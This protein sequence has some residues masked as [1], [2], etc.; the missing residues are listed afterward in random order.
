MIMQ[1]DLLKQKPFF[2]TEEALA[3][4]RD[5]YNSMSL[6]EK[7]GQLFCPWVATDEKAELQE[8]TDRYHIGGILLRELPAEKSRSVQATLQSLSKIP[9]LSSAN[10]ETGGRG[11][12]Y[13]GTFLG[14]QMAIAATSDAQSAYELGHIGAREAKAVG[15]N[16]AF[17]P[18]VDIDFNDRNPITNVRTYGADPAAVL[19][20]ASAFCCGCMEEGVAPTIKH[21]PGD[22]VDDRDQHLVTSINTLS[23]EDWDETYG[24]IYRSL[25]DQGVLSVM[26]AHIALPAY[27]KRLGGEQHAIVPATCSKV[28]LQS[29]LR[30]QLGFNGLIT[31]DATTMIGFC[32]YLP[33]EQ[34][35]PLCI[36][37][38]CDVLLIC[39]DLE[40]DYRFM[41]E[42]Y[43]KGLLSAERLE[44][45]VLRILATKAA[46]GLHRK[47]IVNA[48][49]MSVIGCE[50]HQRI[51]E[52]IV[53]RA[54]TLVKDTQQL[55]PINA[56]KHRRVL[57]EVMGEG[58]DREAA[59]ETWDQLLTEKG[60]LVT[61]YI[62]EP[63]FE[64][65][66]GNVTSFKQ[67]YDLVLYVVLSDAASNNTTVRLHWHTVWGWGNNTPWF[68]KDVPTLMVSMGNPYHLLD[69][70]MIQ[71]YINTY[72]YS[73]L[74]A[75]RTLEKLLG[76]SSFKGQSPVDP[77]C[78]RLDTRQ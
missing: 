4:V 24:R 14:R 49:E 67:Q 1:F 21:F 65:P 48:E 26:A 22:G 40:E 25:I 70:P 73:P 7:I 76:V 77:F 68:V 47:R 27:E 56:A 12:V 8:L 60:F 10:L 64:L 29:L 28:L 72:C 50:E 59:E 2:L 19:E 53:D 36:E 39:K 51:A 41:L 18:V 15:V 66:V 58:S 9:L 37:A 38:G 23:C 34:L 78:G 57:L 69:A 20:M 75:K 43:Q 5:T 44:D 16:W 54:I 6:E 45:A 32:S 74:Y 13:E 63:G 3:W 33:R 11:S 35:V 71:T 30:G 61:R 52:Q 42:G 31:T 62:P 55:L 17:A 46:L